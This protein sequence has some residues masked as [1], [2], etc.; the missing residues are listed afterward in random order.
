M[1]CLTRTTLD[2]AY[3]VSVLSQLMTRHLEIHWSA[4]KEVLKYLKGIIDFG[5]KYTYSF[6]VELIRYLESEW[7]NQDDRISTIG[8]ACNI[9]SRII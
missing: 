4:E 9:G 1:N 6:D 5:L 2:I 8:Y 7:D 3:T